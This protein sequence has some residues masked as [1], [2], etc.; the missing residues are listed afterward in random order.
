MLFGHLVIDNLQLVIGNRKLAIDNKLLVIGIKQLTITAG[1]RKNANLID[2]GDW[3]D[4]SV[5]VSGQSG[6]S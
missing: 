6:V 3:T 4:Q 5:G 1:N 2:K